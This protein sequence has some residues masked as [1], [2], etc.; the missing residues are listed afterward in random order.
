MDAIIHT[1][2]NGSSITL[3]QELCVDNLQAAVLPVVQLACYNNH[4]QVAH[5]IH[6]LVNNEV[7]GVATELLPKVPITSPETSMRQ[8]LLRVLS[9]R[10]ATR[11]ASSKVPCI[12][13]WFSFDQAMEQLMNSMVS[14]LVT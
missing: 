2:G 4:H 6:N 10:R 7:D 11:K 12:V 13:R 1:S 9:D 8:T 3:V 14:V 5:C